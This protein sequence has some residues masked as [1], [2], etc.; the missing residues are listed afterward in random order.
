MPEL[1]ITETARVLGVSIDTVRRRVR[2]G[3]LTARRQQTTRGYAWA[4]Q[5]PAGAIENSAALDPHV[6]EIRHLEA[7]VSEL[8][9]QLDQAREELRAR[10]TEVQS[11]LDLMRSLHSGGAGTGYAEDPRSPS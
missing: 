11:L 3:V 5:V 8:R 2:S 7:V 6:G 9:A 1:S 4:V 10:R